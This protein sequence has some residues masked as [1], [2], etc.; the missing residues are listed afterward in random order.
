LVFVFF[1]SELATSIEVFGIN[2]VIEKK[3]ILG[4]LCILMTAG[5]LFVGLW[6]F[7]PSPKN[8]AYWLANE[9]G[10]YFD[11]HRDRWKLSVGGIAYT[12]SP[13]SSLKSPSHEKGSFTI[14]IRLRPDQDSTDGV[15]QILSFIDGSGREVLYLGQW[16]QSLIVRWFSYDQSGKRLMRAIGVEDAL[17]KKKT[18]RLTVVSNQ[19]ATNIYLDGKLANRFQG[20]ALIGEKESIRGYSIALGNSR[21]VS[22]SWTGSILGLKLYGRS[23]MESEI[24][25]SNSTL[26]RNAVS[27][28]FIAYFSFEQAGGTL[29]PDLSGNENNLEVPER[30]TLHNSVLGWPYLD[31]L[32]KASLESDI[33]VN[34]LGFIPFGFLLALWEEQRDR[35]SRW[36]SCVFAILVGTLISLVIEVTQAFIPVRD[37][38]MVDVICNT[39]GAAI[40]AGCWMLGRW[41]LGTN[42][43]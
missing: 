19:E 40:G 3:R 30:V 24:A 29:I 8:R 18:Q 23:L 35:S 36:R 31:V 38:S 41:V 26:A 32:K 4:I 37:S 16:K 43:S 39:G 14:D 17:I 9:Q 12:P 11:G 20:T 21:K 2:V 6:P 33:A 1:N 25:L 15:P 28:S 27:E 13:L 34:I 22:S 10:L 5:L 7:N 42:S